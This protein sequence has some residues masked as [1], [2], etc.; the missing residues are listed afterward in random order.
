MERWI[1]VYAAR[2]FR[3]LL[4]MKMAMRMGDERLKAAADQTF[5]AEELVVQS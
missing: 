1:N 4:R 3:V 5:A 2:A